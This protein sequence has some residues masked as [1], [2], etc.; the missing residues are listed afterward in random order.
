M[1]LLAQA[2]ADPALTTKAG[3]TAL[4]AAAGVGR[5][6]VESS[7]SEAQAIDAVAVA[8]AAG[9]DIAAANSAGDTALHGAATL[10]WN[11]LVKLLAGKGCAA[12]REEPAG[13]HAVV[14][15]RGLRHRAAPALAR[16]DSQWRRPIA[17]VIA[18]SS[19]S[20]RP[21]RHHLL[22]AGYFR[23]SRM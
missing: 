20:S 4:M 8:L 11:A 5:I 9:N 10:R 21:W 12:R 1:R 19:S 14:E 13:P 22:I 3:T 15:R 18:R 7:V 23:C 6:A 2:G 16:R 17:A